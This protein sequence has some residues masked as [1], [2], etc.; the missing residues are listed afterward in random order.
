MAGDRSQPVPTARVARQFELPVTGVAQDP[1][2]VHHAIS[3]VFDTNLS[4]RIMRLH[5]ARASS[6]NNP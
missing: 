2:H 1:E 5:D 3:R 6:V 4:A